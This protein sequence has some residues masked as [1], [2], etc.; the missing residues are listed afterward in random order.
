M[1]S[2]TYAQTRDRDPG[3]MQSP[4][5][6]ASISGRVVLP[7]GR[8]LSSNVKIVLNNSQSPLNTLYT[9]KH[10]EFRFVNV[11]E[12]TRRPCLSDCVM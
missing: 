9:D 12:G 8:S 5:E 6:T 7:S 3:S 4:S 11:R 10:G 2:A 1:N